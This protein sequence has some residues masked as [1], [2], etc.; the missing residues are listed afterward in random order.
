MPLCV[1]SQRYDILHT[2]AKRFLLQ[3]LKASYSVADRCQLQI[4]CRQ[5]LKVGA[6]PLGARLVN[7]EV[8]QV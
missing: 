5:K 2:S 8:A 4:L 7:A 3:S 1:I 6:L